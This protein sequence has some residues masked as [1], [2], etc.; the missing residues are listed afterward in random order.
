MESLKQ[1]VLSGVFWLGLER[2]GGQGIQFVVSIVLA[3]LLLPEDYGMIAVLLVFTALAGAFIDCGFQVALI[4]KKDLTEADCDSVFWLNLA[5][6]ILIYSLLF[7]CAPWVGDFYKNDKLCLLLRVLALNPVIGSLAIVHRAKLSRG[8]LFALQLRI[9]WLSMVCS[10]VVGISMALGGAGPWA[11]MGQIITNVIISTISYWWFIPW[12]PRWG[13][14]EW[15]SIKTL[16]NFSYKI[17]VV[18]LVDS[19][20]F[21][22]FQLL[23][24]K[25][26]D[27]KTL[28]YYNRGNSLPSVGMMAISNTLGGVMF[29]AF[30]S[31]QTDR[32]QLRKVFS[33]TLQTCMFL[34]IPIMVFCFIMAHSIIIVLLTSKW[35]PCTIFMQIA[36]VT[37]LFWPIHILNLQIIQATGRSELMLKLEIIKK[38]IL[39]IIIVCTISRGVIALAAGMALSSLIS[40]VV[41]AW[42]MEKLIGFGYLKQLR[43]IFP[44]LLFSLLSGG[45]TSLVVYG[46]S[47]I[48]FKL[49][50]G[51]ILFCGLYF[52]FCCGLKQNPKPILQ[53]L[54]ALRK[55]FLH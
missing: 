51:G 8:M 48:Y 14:F 25:C 24:G 46:V 49:F 16:F 47:N 40:S 5:S 7:V 34:V 52:L 6:G 41:N 26:F 29:P 45:V 53:I 31:I 3:R 17:L 10:A 12:R 15:S 39:L 20:F 43:L 2:F 32:E 33:V 38:A 28:A 44:Y 36:A 37:Y 23:V 11:L 35:E 42:S 22:G 50:A 30:S 1:K 4:Q 9:N 21:N 55:K 54:P 18:G 13:D 27:I 19:A